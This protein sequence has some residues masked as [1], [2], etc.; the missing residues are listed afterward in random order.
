MEHKS[1]KKNK[2]INTLL[3]VLV[4]I[5]LTLCFSMGVKYGK[6]L[7]QQHSIKVN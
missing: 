1:P 4:I 7:A 3:V 2:T 5:A 6:N